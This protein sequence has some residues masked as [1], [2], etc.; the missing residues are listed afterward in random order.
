MNA[1]DR[2]LRQHLWWKKMEE[3]RF[4]WFGHVWKRPIEALVKRVDQ[5]ECSSLQQSEVGEDQKN[6]RSVKPL[7]QDLNLNGFFTRHDL[8][9]I[10]ME[11]FDLCG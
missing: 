11:S 8:Q 5:M 7:K 2:K 4:R 9:Y 1:L 3:Y 10:I 6:Y